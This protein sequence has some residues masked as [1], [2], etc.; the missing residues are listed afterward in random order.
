MTPPIGAA[1]RL[2][3]VIGDPVAHSLS[4]VL[5]NTAYAE[6]DV[7]MVYVAIRVPP[8]SVARALD[9]ASVLG[10]VGLSVTMPHKQSVARLCDRLES[11]ASR[12]GSVN[13]VTF[14][15]EAVGASTDG[16]GFVRSLREAGVDPDGR[17]SLVLG[18][19]GAGLAVAVALERSGS[20]VA[21]SARRPE[22]ARAAAEL[23][24]R[25]VA[26]EWDSRN[27]YVSS[28]DMVVNATPIGMAPV[29]ARAHGGALGSAPLATPVDEEALRPE[30]VVA[31]LVYHP[32]R[33][34]LLTLAAE[35]G[36]RP[37]DGLGMLVHQA[38]LQVELWTGRSAPVAA[39]RSAAEGSLAS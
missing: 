28:V 23:L 19:G 32:R 2:A 16:E 21:V 9:A 3:A 8:A 34:R 38:G 17:R 30:L 25:G 27:E 35:C 31:D 29:D 13:T 22:R 5:H 7:D 24:D 39:M 12:L 37:V 4:P 20:G 6:L 26:V 1:T 14:D 33:T 11:D 36:A 18:A 15:G 10:F